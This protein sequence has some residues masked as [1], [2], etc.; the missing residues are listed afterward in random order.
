MLRSFKFSRSGAV[1]SL[2]SKSIVGNNNNIARLEMGCAPV[3]RLSPELIRSLT[4]AFREAEASTCK[5]I[6]LA[7]S[8]RAFCAGL[9]LN[10]L[11]NK[12][13]AEL[14]EYWMAFQDLCFQMYGSKKAVIAEISGSAPG[15]GTIL[16]MCC[17]SRVAVKGSKHGI[18]G[19]SFGMYIPA[20]GVELYVNTV[21]Y[22]LACKALSLG[23]LYDSSEALKLGLIDKESSAESLVS[24]TIAECERWIASPGREIMKF[25]LRYEVLERWKRERDVDVGKF[26]KIVTTPETQERIRKHHDSLSAK[27]AA[28]ASTQN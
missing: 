4:N 9:D 21:G 17:D 20:S 16:T 2:V 8:C 1:R 15:G 6:I 18:T 25:E 5:G 7:S 26:L 12:T 27:K 24:D 3:N 22:P 13:P 19:A 10:E 14:V 11:Y 28:A 23:F